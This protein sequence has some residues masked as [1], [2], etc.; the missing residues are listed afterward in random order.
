MASIPQELKYSKEHEWVRI[1][2]ER[3]VIGITD[4]A[5]SELGDVVYVELPELGAAVAQMGQIGTIESVKAASDLY[6]PVSGEVIG[7]NG[8]LGSHPELVNND[9]Y[10][11]GWLLE[12][13][14]T[15]W[16]TE[17]KQLLAAAVYEQLTAS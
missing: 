15:N 5:Q 12:M 13:R 4:F 2:G 10:G 9:P 17:R 1:D 7:V 6:A 16:D 11:G 14:T 8:E 3:A